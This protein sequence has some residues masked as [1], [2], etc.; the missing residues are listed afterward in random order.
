M[1]ALENAWRR[2]EK[3]A[4]SLARPW[5]DEHREPDAIVD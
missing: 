5:A 1:E 2:Y 4:Y 3:G